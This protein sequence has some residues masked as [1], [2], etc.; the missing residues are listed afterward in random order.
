VHTGIHRFLAVAGEKKGQV[1]EISRFM[2]VWR[3][4]ADGSRLSR[5]ISYDTASN[6]QAAFDIAFTISLVTSLPPPRF[7]MSAPIV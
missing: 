2:D 1:L 6:S 7:V 5:V 4:D 3:S